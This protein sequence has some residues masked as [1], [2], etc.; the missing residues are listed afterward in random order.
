M[1]VVCSGRLSRS[2]VFPRTSCNPPL[3]AGT[4]IYLPLS[5]LTGPAAPVCVFFAP[6]LPPN[7]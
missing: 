2:D 7:D 4:Y 5:F 3:L 6:H 1:M